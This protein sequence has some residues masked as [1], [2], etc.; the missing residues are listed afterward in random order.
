MS[1]GGFSTAGPSWPHPL[2]AS[3]ISPLSSVWRLG[4]TRARVAV[5]GVRRTWVIGLCGAN[6]EQLRALVTRPVPA[7]V[8]WRWP[9]SYAVIEEG[10]EEIVLRTDPAASFPLYATRWGPGWAW[11][12]SARI[13]AALT[14]ATLDKRRLACAV[15]A[16]SVPALAEGRT[17]FAGVDQLA[18]GSRIALPRDGSVPRH[19][20]VWRPDP[21]PERPAHHRLRQ[22]LE[23]GTALR[24]QSD[25]HLTSDLSGGLDSSPLAILASLAL[26]EPLSLNAVTIHPLGMLDGADLRY[27]R[28]VAALPMS[29]I[30]HRLLPMGVEHRPYSQISSVPPTDEPA[31]STLTQ[32]RLIGQFR[33]MRDHLGSQTHLT[34]DGGDSV[35]FQPPAHLSD[36]VRQGRWRQAMRQTYG[37]ARLQRAPV[38]P[39]L[40]A[41]ITM[42]RTTR[43]EAATELAE[44]IARRDSGTRSDLQWFALPPVPGWAR[45]A[46]IME[47]TDAAIDMSRR[48]DPLPGL[49]AS[50]RTL[51]DEIREVARTAAADG[52]LASSC[53]IDLHN[54]FLDAAV[55]D[56]VLRN[57]MA[58][59][60][61]PHSYKPLLIAAVGD[62]L[63]A[64]LSVRATK[65]SFEADHYVGMRANIHL[66]LPLIDG[67][68][69]GLGLVDPTLLRR[70]LH[71]AA[72]GVPVPLASI[73]QALTVE[74]WLRAHHRE[75]VPAWR[76][77]PDQAST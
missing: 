32:A 63:P 73:E 49:D 39:L 53:G 36:L 51:V 56:S 62:L 33:W 69:A 71:H 3:R 25:M 47:L 31:P 42:A 7:D 43:S 17:Y 12:T 52:E 68:L 29:R 59:R 65:G 72:V 60:S 50:V 18:P 46:A 48:T 1:V 15:L 28:M 75:P 44:R 22:A 2:G 66:L 35:L 40:R 55:V 16:P 37:W 67:H 6:D 54:P 64:A 57:P 76:Y 23:Q 58:H 26:P 74:A 14:G 5:F 41:A 21:D 77:T 20:T 19:Q 13:L 4:R 38:A 9:G 24:V 45:E 30:R 27:A 10:P 8:T 61:P 34:G 11:A 70:H